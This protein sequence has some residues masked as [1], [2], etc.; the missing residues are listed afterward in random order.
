MKFED[1]PWGTHFEDG[2]GRK[3]IKIQTHSAFGVPFSCIMHYEKYGEHPSSDLPFNSVD[4]K[5]S[6][7]KCPAWLP[8]KI[9]KKVNI[10]RGS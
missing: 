9:L 6:P 5:G 4:Y 10:C 3:F 8:F 2:N 7:G 1:M